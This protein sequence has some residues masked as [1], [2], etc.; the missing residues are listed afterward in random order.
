MVAG[1]VTNHRVANQIVPW[2][3]E[4]VSHRWQEHLL[5]LREEPF[6][7]NVA[8]HRRRGFLQRLYHLRS[9]NDNESSHVQIASNHRL[10]LTCQHR[11]DFGNWP[12]CKGEDEDYPNDLEEEKLARAT[13]G[14]SRSPS[15]KNSA[16]PLDT[17]ASPCT[18]LLQAFCPMPNIKHLQKD[19]KHRRNKDQCMCD[20]KC[21]NL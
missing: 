11:H 1:C 3:E 19:M 13:F 20:G 12:K 21:C 7:G 16:V 5:G 9:W 15:A 14:C 8:E 2:E 17:V 6:N 10:S 4:G 18:S